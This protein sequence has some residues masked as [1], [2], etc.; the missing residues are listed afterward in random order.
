MNSHASP[1]SPQAGDRATH[2]K[3]GHWVLLIIGS[4]LTVLG[5]GLTVG[6]STLTGADLIQRDGRYLQGAV[7]RYQTTGYALTAPSLVIDSAEAGLTGAPDLG[8][9]ASIRTRISPAVPNQEIFVGIAETADADAYLQGVATASLGNISWSTDQ[10]STHPSRVEEE[11]EHQTG[12]RAPAPPAGQDFWT[13]SSSGTGPQQLTWDLDAGNW[14]MVVMNADA[15]RPVWV[16]LQAGVR[17]EVI[18]PAGTALLI[19]GIAALILGVP[20]LL[21]GAARLGRDIHRATSSTAPLM[22]D[23]GAP[24]PPVVYPVRFTG[25][26][27]QRLSRGLWLVKWLLAIPHFI[28]LAVLWFALLVTT[29][30]AG[31]AIL[32][33]GRYPRSWFAFSVGVLRWTWRVGFYAYSA[34][35]TD[36]YPPFTLAASDYPADLDVT[37]PEHL[38]RGLVL[39]KWWLLAIPHLIIIGILTGTTMWGADDASPGTGWGPSLLGI[40]VLIAAVILLFTGHY[41][42]SIFALIIG[43]NRW[44]YRAG[45][46]ILLMTDKY[47]PFRLDQGP[48]DPIPGP[49]I[50]PSMSSSE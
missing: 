18:G 11:L 44:V 33:T 20:L 8:E 41:R 30:A 6:G 15:T 49:Q 37:Y 5:L 35:G 22:A 19:A 2:A 10:E 25:Y 4:L 23:H 27:D 1:A 32:F 47:P 13:E 21:F 16:D 7:E 42:N 46:Y 40:L 12:Q 36:M 26:L 34:L 48:I 9:L 3:P 38:S 14:T 17:S 50:P 45:A 24:P 39:V 29:I 31:I 43:I 28:V